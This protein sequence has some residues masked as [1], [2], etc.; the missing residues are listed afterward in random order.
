M[1]GKR[2]RNSLRCFVPVSVYVLGL[3]PCTT[4]AGGDLLY[5]AN[6]FDGNPL[7]DGLDLHSAY[8]LVWLGD[9]DVDQTKAHSGNT[10]SGTYD[11][12]MLHVLGGG[13]VWRF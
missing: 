8:T 11:N 13:A 6:Q 9:M 10:L 1:Q 3:W 5:E 12:A 2:Y 7:A 4:W